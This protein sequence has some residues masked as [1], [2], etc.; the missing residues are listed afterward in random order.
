MRARMRSDSD[1]VTSVDGP[2]DAARSATGRRACG[3]P[4]R[5]AR[6]DRGLGGLQ[7]GESRPL[8]AL[9]RF[10]ETPLRAPD[11]RLED[12]DE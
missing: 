9:W 11:G 8:G 5:L 4:T 1:I 6:R 10:F 2:I 12:D 3:S 7:D